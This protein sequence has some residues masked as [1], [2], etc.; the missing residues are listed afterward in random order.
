MHGHLPAP[1]SPPELVEH[2][3]FLYMAN[4]VTTVRGMQGNPRALEHRA[5]IAARRLLAPVDRH[6]RCLP[7]VRLRLHGEDGD[8]A[9]AAD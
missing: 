2:I 3:L 8:E 7:E 4:G 1:D 5:A 6:R 9:A